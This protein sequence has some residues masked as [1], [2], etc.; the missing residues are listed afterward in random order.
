[1]ASSVPISSFA[2][3]PPV[4]SLLRVCNSDTVRPSGSDPSCTVLCCPGASSQSPQ[5]AL[6][7]TE[8]ASPLC[9]RLPPGRMMT[10]WTAQNSAPMRLLGHVSVSADAI[11]EKSQSGNASLTES[12]TAGSGSFQVARARAARR[13]SEEGGMIALVARSRQGRPFGAGTQDVQGRRSILR[14]DRPSVKM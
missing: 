11:E 1:M 12:G 14:D 8:K 2:C 7:E 3:P 13:A 6:T 4:I 9:Q 10:T 5:S